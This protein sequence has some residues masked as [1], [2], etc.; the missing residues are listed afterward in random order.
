M[1]QKGAEDD[2]KDSGSFET[3]NCEPCQKGFAGVANG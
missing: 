3:E 2:R 1:K